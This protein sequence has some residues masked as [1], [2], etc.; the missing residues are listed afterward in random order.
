LVV[1][2]RVPDYEATARRIG[3][4]DWSRSNAIW[5]DIVRERADKEGNT[6]L[7]LAAGGAQSRRF[8]T[9]TIR[10]RLHIDTLLDEKLAD[11]LGLNTTPAR[12]PVEV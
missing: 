1:T 2:L 6:M 11:D 7:G 12:E 3:S 8:M 10:E 9:K 4:I 5:L